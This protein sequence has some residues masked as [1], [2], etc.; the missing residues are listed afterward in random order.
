MYR[1]SRDPRVKKSAEL[2]SNG[3]ITCSHS[4][5]YNDI[6]ISDIQQA[7]GVSR[8]TFYRIFD[9]TEDVLLYICDKL[10]MQVCE[11]IKLAHS[12]KEFSLLFLEMLMEQADTITLFFES[13]NLNMFSHSLEKYLHE[14]DIH[15]EALKPL[16]PYTI[17]YA[18]RLFSTSIS[19]LLSVWIEHGKTE[20][21]TEVYDRFTQ[22]MQYM[23]SL[24]YDTM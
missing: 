20:T 6:T 14:Y 8:S 17:D 11:K 12:S 5:K 1:I 15:F 22:C 18:L 7:S 21:P 13:D 9:N 10:C 16:D 24:F 19:C 3:F 23:E 2:I 4:K